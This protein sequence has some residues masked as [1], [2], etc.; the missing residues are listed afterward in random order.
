MLSFVLLSKKKK[1]QMIVIL[2][3]FHVLIGYTHT[4]SVGASIRDFLLKIS[5]IQHL[6]NSLAFMNQF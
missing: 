6:D 5:P 4:L 1:S 3:A 2:H